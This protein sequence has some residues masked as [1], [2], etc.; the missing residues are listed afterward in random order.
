MTQCSASAPQQASMMLVG[1]DFSS[2]PHRRKPIVV[3][4]GRLSHQTVVVHSFLRF[5]SLAQWGEWMHRPASWVGAFDFP[6]GLPRELVVQLGWPLDWWSCM[7]HFQS[8][9]RA[10]IRHTFKQFCDGRPSGHKFAH[11][12]TDI[13]A[14][15]SSS[16]KWVNPPVA[17]M[18]HAGVPY[19]QDEHSG[20][21]VPGLCP[22]P[23]A[24]KVALEAYPGL[25]VREIIGAR[26]Y[27]SDTRARQTLE[28]Q[29]ARQAIVQALQAHRTHFGLGVV[30]STDHLRTIVDDG[31]GDALDAV[32][33]LVQA[34]YG[35]QQYGA[36]D[37]HYGLPAQVDSL[38][39]WIVTA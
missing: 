23:C 17:F 18:L 31:S 29:Q 26:S 39:G 12:A 10:D 2:S 34:A 4:T 14:K 35:W 6:F 28:R 13:P 19:L 1:C 20:I 38:E 5:D 33:C 21:H 27:K 32:L 8:L 22:R 25:L 15:S 9:S 7:R 3:A 36:G 37:T 11:R 30:L 24:T 16:M